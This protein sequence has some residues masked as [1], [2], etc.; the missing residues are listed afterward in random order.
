M[1][2]AAIKSFVVE[3]NHT[4]V[5]AEKKIKAEKNHILSL[6]IQQQATPHA[7]LFFSL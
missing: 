7:K 2:K 6:E 3:K 1:Q 5:E 4:L